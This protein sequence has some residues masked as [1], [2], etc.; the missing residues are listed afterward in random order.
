M[1]KDFERRR[2][3]K[4]GLYSDRM[5]LSV[6]ETQEDGA[7][8]FCLY[9]KQLEEDF[10]NKDGKADCAKIL[11]AAQRLMKTAQELLCAEIF[12]F[13]YGLLRYEEPELREY[14]ERELHTAV[15]AVS[16]AEQLRAASAAMN[17][18]ACAAEQGKSVCEIGMYSSDLSTQLFSCRKGENLQESFPLGWR[19]LWQTCGKI[20]PDRVEEEQM[21]QEIKAI[22]ERLPLVHEHGAERIQAAGLDAAA[23]FILLMSGAENRVSETIC[24]ERESFAPIFRALRNP[25]LRWLGTLEQAGGK[26]PQKVFCQLMIL[27]TVMRCLDI[28]EAV[29]S[30]IFLED[31]LYSQKQ[32]CANEI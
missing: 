21:R 32:I 23:K 1:M 3:A 9:R 29:L 10:L 26:F 25:S 18:Q 14:L 12:C 4:I 20:I 30:Q 24:I 16:G 7:S 6:E 15:Y 2:R 5:V 31:Y 11:S 22:L 8:S 19:I 27:E 28:K 13:G 17:V